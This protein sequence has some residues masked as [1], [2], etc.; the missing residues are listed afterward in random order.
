MRDPLKIKMTNITSL[1]GGTITI[2]CVLMPIYSINFIVS[3]TYKLSDIQYIVLLGQ[4][5]NIKPSYIALL[6]GAFIIYGSIT[7]KKRIVIISGVA[8]LMLF[9]AINEAVNALVT[10]EF[11]KGILNSILKREAGFYVLLVS[12]IL[13]ILGGMAWDKIKI[14]IDYVEDATKE[15]QRGI[16]W[17]ERETNITCSKEER[18]QKN[19]FLERNKEERPKEKVV[20]ESIK[21]ETQERKHTMTFIAVLLIFVFILLYIITWHQES[22]Q[23]KTLTHP[24]IY[25]GIY[26]Y[27]NNGNVNEI[28][29][30]WKDEYHQYYY[31]DNDGKGSN[32]W[33][34]DGDDWKYCKD[35]LTLRMIWITGDN[36]ISNSKYIVN[37]T[38]G[39]YYVDAYGNMVKDKEV[40]IEGKDYRFDK[41]GKVIR[42]QQ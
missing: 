12:G 8:T 20:F 7:E 38:N 40:T 32:G 27:D 22:T 42:K 37:E 26:H 14:R 16:L 25:N 5:I 1:L 10:T 29:K 28:G 36:K 35:G 31:F 39:M 24:T 11:E 15:V 18:P 4:Q 6:L 13:S 23:H 19:V 17:N 34:K 41:D 3:Q 30:K 9:V 2:L 33:I 21:E